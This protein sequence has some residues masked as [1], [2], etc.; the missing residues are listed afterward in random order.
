MEAVRKQGKGDGGAVQVGWFSEWKG[1]AMTLSFVHIRLER[2]RK[3]PTP[4]RAKDRGDWTKAEL[5]SRPAVTNCLADCVLPK[6]DRRI[7]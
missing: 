7:G 1:Q 6:R 4:Y 3:L 5:S 2:T